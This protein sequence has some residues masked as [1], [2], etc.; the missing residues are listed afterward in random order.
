MSAGH[1]AKKALHPSNEGATR[2]SAAGRKQ[3][4][5]R[6]D[7]QAESEARNTRTTKEPATE[8]RRLSHTGEGRHLRQL[9]RT[10]REPGQRTR[11]EWQ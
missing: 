3:P 7:D 8:Q 5:K 4:L 9:E 11:E 10:T 2:A 1:T 6:K